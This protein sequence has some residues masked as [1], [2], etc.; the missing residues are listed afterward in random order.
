[1]KIK[2]FKGNKGVSEVLGTVL[3]LGIAVIIFASLMIYVMSIDTESSSPD[4]QMV[5][6]VDENGHAVVEHRGGDQLKAEDMKVEI[7][8]GDANSK[9]SGQ[10]F[11]DILADEDENIQWNVGEFIDIDCQ[12][13]FGGIRHWQI[14][15]IIVDKTSN[16]II[17][18]GVLQQGITDYIIN[19]ITELQGK[20]DFEWTPLPALTTAPV[21]F[22]DLSDDAQYIDT[23][24]WTFDDGN[25]SDEQHPT[26]IFPTS[27]TYDVNLT[28]GYAPEVIN[29]EVGLWNDSIV[30]SV[31]VYQP[32][33]ADFTATYDS[34]TV[35]QVNEQVQF[36]ASNSTGT[37]LI[38]SAP[39]TRYYWDWEGDGTFDNDSASKIANH[40]WG[41]P[42]T[43]TIILKITSPMDGYEFNATTSMTLRVNAPPVASFTYDPS[44]PTYL[45]IIQFTDTTTDPDG[46]A[47]NW[48]WDFGD[49]N[50]SYDQ[51]PQHNYP[52]EGIY[53][54]SLTVRDN[55]NATNTTSR[56]ID[57]TKIPPVADFTYYPPSP[58]T[59]VPITFTDNSSDIDGNITAWLWEFGEGNTSTDQNP[60]HTY[61]T[62]GTY[63]VNLTV[64]D[65]DGLTDTKTQ[66]LTVNWRDIWVNDS[67]KGT[68]Y[69]TEVAPGKFYGINAFD[70][71]NMAITD[72]LP[73]ESVYI[74]N[75]L[76]D[77][78][79]G[80]SA[81]LVNKAITIRG[82]EREN[83]NVYGTGLHPVMIVTANGAN[84]SNITFTYES[85]TTS[86]I[87]I[88]GDN[89]VFHNNNITTAK[90]GVEIL[91]GATGN[92]LVENIISGCSYGM[93]LTNTNSNVIQ[94][95]TIS[96]CL[97]NG[98][99]IVDCADNVVDN[100]DIGNNGLNGILIESSDASSITNNTIHNNTYGIYLW[101][102]IGNIIK[103]NDVYGN[104]AGIYCEGENARKTTLNEIDNNTIHHNQNAIHFEE[105]SPGN[106]I[107]YNTIHNNSNRGIN[108]VLYANQEND[109]NLFHHNNLINNTLNA[110]DECTNNWNA[111]T[112]GNYWDDY[113]GVDSETD[114]I[115][116]TPY[117]VPPPAGGNHDYLPL[118]SKV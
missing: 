109:D 25:T 74:L 68:A 80:V 96:D 118:M 55:D 113:S 90:N 56:D 48:T 89:N 105:Y 86:A 95:N 98:I 79:V 49:G 43:Y 110:Y 60:V 67:W 3:L 117:E 114:G 31:D 24:D 94:Q 104:N 30:K 71:I 7:W 17:M 12:A 52:V 103:N 64:T 42:G 77:E 101:Q 91:S 37:K 20:A 29:P 51:H 116:D 40:A 8:K 23:W 81:I 50:S 65:N 10:A 44:E 9:F 106:I 54:V 73:L 99:E 66:L 59:K 78:Y 61:Y 26:N 88:S 84:I 82:E 11:M 85:Q 14:T 21:A 45:D 62:N 1:M 58:E 38:A 19:N 34:P 93:I 102:A 53:T 18:S 4:V 46:F 28:I 6:Y 76:Y 5:G 70:D 111:S 35:P 13:I 72:A 75:N 27:G 112:A 69:G 97:F 57:V 87:E 15:L 41:T 2:K 22:H 107:T 100:N 39:I 92:I 32:P 36:D 16:S 63:A 83:V 47:V 115:G 108:I 33:V